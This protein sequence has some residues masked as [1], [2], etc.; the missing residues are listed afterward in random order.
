MR[1]GTSRLTPTAPTTSGSPAATT[2]TAITPLASMEIFDCPQVSSYANADGYSNAIGDT[3]TDSHG[4]TGTTELRRHG[5]ARHRIRVP[6]PSAR[7]ELFE[8]GT[9]EAT[10][11]FLSFTDGERLQLKMDG[12]T[13]Q[14]RGS[15]SIGR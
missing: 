3:D 8:L 2:V 5:R 4:D 1:G 12:R 9:R 10:R 14:A 7:L 11:E 15:L 13:P 6:R